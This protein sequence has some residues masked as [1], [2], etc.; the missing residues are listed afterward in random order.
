MTDRRRQL[1]LLGIALL[2]GGVLAIQPAC[3]N[4]VHGSNIFEGGGGNRFRLVI[5]PNRT[6]IDATH[7]LVDALTG[8]VWRLDAAQG[9]SGDWVRLASGP[10]DAAEIPTPG[11]EKAS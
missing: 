3:W 1:R 10:E 6:D 4:G 8:D 2:G 7:F 9:T 5:E 11:E